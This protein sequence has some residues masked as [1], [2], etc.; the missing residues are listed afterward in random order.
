MLDFLHPGL[1][2]QQENPQELV[3]A[4]LLAAEC[5][6]G[7]QEPLLPLFLVETGSLGHCPQQ[8]V[9]AQKLLFLEKVGKNSDQVQLLNQG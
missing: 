4:L 3:E 8:A 1:H 5:L 2:F 7:S 9:W 6:T